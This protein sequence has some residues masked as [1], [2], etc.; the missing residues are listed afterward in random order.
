MNAFT[1][2]LEVHVAG[3]ISVPFRMLFLGFFVLFWFVV[4]FFPVVCNFQSVS[5]SSIFSKVSELSQISKTFWNIALTLHERN[6]LAFIL[7]LRSG[8]TV[9]FGNYPHKVGNKGLNKGRGKKQWLTNHS[10]ILY[11]KHN[12]VLKMLILLLFCQSTLFWI[13]PNRTTHLITWKLSRG[14]NIFYMSTYSISL[15]LRKERSMWLREVN[16]R[17]DY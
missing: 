4:V 12:T 17:S 9:G 5:I 3:N 16:V 2:T 13:Q 14:K 10:S 1:L 11:I 7:S 8:G 15:W 6:K